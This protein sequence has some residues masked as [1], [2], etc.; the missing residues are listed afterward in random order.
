MEDLLKI[1]WVMFQPFLRFYSYAP[2]DRFLA[3]LGVFQPFLRF[4]DRG[5]R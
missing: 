2:V 1:F 5:S 3:Q 4:Y